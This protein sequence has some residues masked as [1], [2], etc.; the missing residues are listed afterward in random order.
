MLKIVCFVAFLAF[1]SGELNIITENGIDAAVDLANPTVFF[2]GVEGAGADQTLPYLRNEYVFV[3]EVTKAGSTVTNGAKISTDDGYVRTTDSCGEADY[4]CYYIA[5]SNSGGA[6]VNASHT[7]AYTANY[8][9]KTTFTADRYTLP[10]TSFLPADVKMRE[11]SWTVNPGNYKFQFFVYN[12]QWGS[13]ATHFRIQMHVQGKN[14][15]NLEFWFNDDKTLNS[16]ASVAGM[17]LLN[18]HFNGT[19][20]SGY[21]VDSTYTFQQKFNIGDDTFRAV[22]VTGEAGTPNGMLISYDLA[23]ADLSDPSGWFLYDP[24]I[25]STAKLPANSASSLAAGMVT[26]VAAVAAVFLA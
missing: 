7:I 18:V 23:K 17:Q 24:D 16:V 11:N 19:T 2:I 8:V 5:A 4:H 15:D 10:V 26:V 1:A 12:W 13:G 20:T 6:T 25:Q 14:M 22:S 3:G 21:E 9:A